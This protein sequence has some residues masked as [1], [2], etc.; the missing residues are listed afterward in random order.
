MP[1]Q[2]TELKWKLV[3]ILGKGLIDLFFSRSR[4][5]SWGYEPVKPHMEARRFIAAIW[6]SRI[7]AFSYLY[8]GWDAAILVSKSDD[9]EI[10]ARI[11]QKQGFETVRG[12]TTHGGGKALATLIR[13]IR[14]GKPAVIIPDGPQGPRYR[15]QPGIIAL[16]RKTGLPILPMTYSAEKAF[17]FNSWDRFMLPS[18]LN[19]YLVIYGPPVWVPQD[20]DGIVEEQCRLELEDRLY[21]ITVRADIHFNRSIP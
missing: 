16:A 1:P 17:V 7:L 20:A 19:R 11:L 4:I 14:A 10:I 8:K 18:P 2:L 12:S 21:A 3:G 6:H 5:E 13:R 9:G 15:I